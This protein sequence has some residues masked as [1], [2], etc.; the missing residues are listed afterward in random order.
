MRVKSRTHRGTKMG[1]ARG[2][3]EY[4]GVDTNVPVAFFDKQHPDHPEV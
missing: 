1:N 4:L 3:K 2:D